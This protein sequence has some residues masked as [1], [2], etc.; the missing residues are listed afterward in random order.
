MERQSFLVSFSDIALRCLLVV[1]GLLAVPLPSV[2]LFFMAAD[3]SDSRLDDDGPFF[4]ALGTLIVTA[5]VYFVCIVPV[6]WR[7]RFIGAGRPS[8][9]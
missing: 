6:I 3:L 7:K 2:L 8:T 5:V 4:W 9:T 1:A